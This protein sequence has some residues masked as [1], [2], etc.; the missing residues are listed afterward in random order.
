MPPHSTHTTSF[1]GPLH[2]KPPF[3]YPDHPREPPMLVPWSYLSPLKLFKLASPK[4][5]YPGFFPLWKPQEKLLPVFAQL[6]L[7]HDKP[8]CFL[9]GPLPLGSCDYDK[10]SFRGSWLLICWL[11]HTRIIRPMASL[12][13]QTIKNL[14]AMQET[15]VQSLGREDPLEKGMETHSSI[16]V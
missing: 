14:P 15:Q 4:P 13:V 12:V 3:L 7:P 9:R 5:V 8:W 2:P 11:R 1:K 16:L 10:P 6:P